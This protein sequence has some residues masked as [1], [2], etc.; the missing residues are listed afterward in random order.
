MLAKDLKNIRI[1]LTLCGR[2][3]D[4]AFDFNAMAEL[5][6][7]YEGGFD[8]AMKSMEEGKSTLKTIRALIYSAIKPRYPKI[9]LVEVGE[10]L[11][12]ALQ[13]EEKMQY[14]SE[15]LQK[16][17]TLAMPEQNKAEVS[18][19]GEQKPQTVK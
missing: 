6:D 13:S 11:T 9:T 5:E 3:F 2:T 8:R 16:A 4:I 15:T 18:E 19:E 17:M 14:V 1:P 12:E 10:L 7:I